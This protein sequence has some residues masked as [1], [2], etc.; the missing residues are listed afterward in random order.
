MGLSCGFVKNGE[1]V[2]LDED[3]FPFFGYET[4]FQPGWEMAEVVEEVT[5]QSLC[6]DRID[7][8]TLAQMAATMAAN[9]PDLT[10]DDLPFWEELTEV[11]QHY[12]R[13]GCDYGGDW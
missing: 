9:T 13:L 5:G 6:Q 2:A 12:A 10:E 11:F 4:F 8:A 1:I 3:K 7:N